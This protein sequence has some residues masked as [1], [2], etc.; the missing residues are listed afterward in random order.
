MLEDWSCSES[1][2][3]V[4][5]PDLERD[6]SSSDARATVI[7]RGESSG[8]QQINAPENS[9]SGLDA[10]L[11]QELLP[12]CTSETTNALVLS[13]AENFIARPHSSGIVS[14]EAESVAST[15]AS[16]R[17]QRV[18]NSFGPN[19][20]LSLL[21]SSITGKSLLERSKQGDFSSQSQ[22]ELVGIVAEHHL[23][24]GIKTTEDA[25]NDYATAIVLLFKQEKKVC[26]Y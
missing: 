12:A 25:L 7:F 10:N 23:S 13:E 26:N 24:L 6:S 20:L 8:H 22:K 2:G 3:E 16:V 5:E 19:Q 15:V 18:G 17:L 4:A 1:Q 14:T 11:T 21:E 9:A